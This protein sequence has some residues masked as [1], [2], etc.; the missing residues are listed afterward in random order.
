VSTEIM[1]CA[2]THNAS[3]RPNGSSAANT[4]VGKFTAA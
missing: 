3:R 4:A 1:L 2:L